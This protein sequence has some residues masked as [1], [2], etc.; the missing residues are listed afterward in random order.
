MV[1]KFKNMSL[2]LEG[3]LKNLV[4]EMTSKLE[5]MQGD[6]MKMFVR[7]EKLAQNVQVTFLKRVAAIEN[8]MK[9]QLNNAKKMTIQ[10]TVDLLTKVTL[11]F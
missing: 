3:K 7:V 4:A 9:V 1:L 8:M 11:K 10:Q 5:A 2:E 6:M